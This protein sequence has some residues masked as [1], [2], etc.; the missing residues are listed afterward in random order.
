VQLCSCS[1]P[2]LLVCCVDSKGQAPSWLRRRLGPHLAGHLVADALVEED[3]AVAHEV[4]V[5]VHHVL[6]GAQGKFSGK[7]K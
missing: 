4:A 1:S 5:Q 7:T 2:R 6:K 3:D